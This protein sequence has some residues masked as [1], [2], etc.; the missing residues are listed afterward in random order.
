MTRWQ[1]FRWLHTAALAYLGTSAF[2]WIMDRSLSHGDATLLWMV[3][4]VLFWGF[5]GGSQDRSST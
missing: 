3:L 4:F 1:V 5:S 2:P